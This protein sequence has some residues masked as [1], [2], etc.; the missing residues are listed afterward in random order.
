[1]GQIDVATTST[2]LGNVI[3]STGG[4]LILIVLIRAFAWKQITSIFTARAKKIND[5]IDAAEEAHKTAAELVETRQK[6][7]NGAKAEAA[8]I[9][10]TANETARQNTDKA[11][12]AAQAEAE[13]I[14]N[15]ATADIEQE[16]KEAL[17]S[18]KSDVANI[19]VQIA[20]K[21]IGKNLSADDQ[22]ALIDEYIAKLG[23]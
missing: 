1:M 15:R 6:E 19:S 2:V 8:G 10:D 20:E 7:L 9:I 16:R 11:T 23:D 14:K 4:F 18:V 5:D 12:K 3:I 13:A 21:L 22:S 17:G